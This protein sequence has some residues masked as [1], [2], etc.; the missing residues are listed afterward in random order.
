M[1]SSFGFLT[2]SQADTLRE[3]LGRRNTT[4]L[5]KIQASD[6]VTRSDAQTLVSNLSDELTDNLDDEW[7][8]TAYGQI[9]SEILSRVN[10]AQIA[11]WP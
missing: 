2:S 3:I 5:E 1:D 4:L 7:E 9:V 10:S 6:L 11:Q 8:P